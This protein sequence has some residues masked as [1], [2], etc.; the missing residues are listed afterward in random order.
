MS[1][2][3]PPDLSRIKE[4]NP[5]TLGEDYPVRRVVVETTLYSAYFVPTNGSDGPPYD[6]LVIEHPPATA[7]SA[8]VWCRR[9]Q[10]TGTKMEVVKEI[11]NA[12]DYMRSRH[13]K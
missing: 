8:F 6:I 2:L 13:D 11:S 9:I 1:A 4:L 5:D 12:I 10:G 7:I 3:N